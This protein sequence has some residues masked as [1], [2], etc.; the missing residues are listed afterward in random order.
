LDDAIDYAKCEVDS[1]L[2]EIYK[3]GMAAVELIN[4]Y[5]SGA[6]EPLVRASDDEPPVTFKTLDYV[7]AR[8]AEICGDTQPDPNAPGATMRA[9]MRE[10]TAQ[11]EAKYGAEVERL[12]EV[13]L[14]GRG[15]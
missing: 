6:E 8:C 13:G 14:K 1:S 7:R 9:A 4:D 2:L 11:L 15:L 3:P 12:V 5:K 10:F